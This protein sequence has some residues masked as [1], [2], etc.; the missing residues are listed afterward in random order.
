MLFVVEESVEGSKYKISLGERGGSW[1]AHEEGIDMS[2]M[3]K[4]PFYVSQHFCPSSVA[5]KRSEM[6]T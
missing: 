5:L 4:W 3:Q 6:K 1:G 2:F